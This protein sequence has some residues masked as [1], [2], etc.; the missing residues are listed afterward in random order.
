MAPRAYWKGYLRLS[1]VTCAIELF[2]ASS[3]ARRL[4]CA[5]ARRLVE[6][7]GFQRDLK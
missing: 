4:F 5:P 1:L 6:L 3:Q 7:I 2:P